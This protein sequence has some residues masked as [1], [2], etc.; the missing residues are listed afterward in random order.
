MFVL[1]AYVR[2]S[3][4]D[5]ICAGVESMKAIIKE[6]SDIEFINLK[7]ERKITYVLYNGATCI[8]S[9]DGSCTKQGEYL[10]FK[11]T[12]LAKEKSRELLIKEL[13]QKKV[14]KNVLQR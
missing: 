9:A 8:I 14:K 4:K 2:G 11:G 5:P 6:I 7:A 1:I 12:E 10:K 13:K 3:T